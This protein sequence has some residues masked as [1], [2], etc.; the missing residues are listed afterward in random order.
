MHTLNIMLPRFRIKTFFET[1]A[2]FRRITPHQARVFQALLSF[3]GVAGCFPSHA[4]LAAEAGV[5]ER[6]V[7]NTLREGRMR[8]W[9]DWTNERVGRRQTSNRYRVTLSA[10]YVND[11]LN[12]LR[13]FK[14]KTAEICAFFRRQMLPGSPYFYINR[15]RQNIWKRVEQ[16]YIQPTPWQKLFKENPQAAIAQY[17]A[18]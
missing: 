1:L 8:G 11:V 16:A 4:T 12:G 17:L 13:K 10:E 6:T 14:Q 9:I 15:A 18:S 3:S 2:R 5:S 7:R